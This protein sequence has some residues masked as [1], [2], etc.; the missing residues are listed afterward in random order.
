[1]IRPLVAAVLALALALPVHARQEGGGLSERQ[2]EEL[3][4]ML[5]RQDRGHRPPVLDLRPR[6]RFEPHAPFGRPPPRDRPA[7]SRGIAP[8]RCA[9]LYD[10]RG[11]LG[12]GYEWR[13]MQAHADR[14]TALPEACVRRVETRAGP[15]W[16][17]PRG[18]LHRAG[19][20]VW[21]RR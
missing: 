21:G 15:R 14:S 19:W 20:I 6:D 10:G 8:D 3:L 13:C 17:Y 2:L 7:R 12:L 1:M 4:T 16:A 11:G 18:C 9:V 5:L